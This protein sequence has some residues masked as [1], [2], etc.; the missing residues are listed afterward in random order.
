MALPAWLASMTQV[1]TATKVTAAP[2]M[3]QFALVDASIEKVTGVA[4]CPAARRDG[5][6]ASYDGGAGWVEVK[7]MLWVPGSGSTDCWTWVAAA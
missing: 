5:V 3:L 6:G 1:P 2:E 4:T 7:V